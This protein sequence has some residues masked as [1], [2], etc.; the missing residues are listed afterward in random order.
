MYQQYLDILAEC[1]ANVFQEMTRTEILS[2]RIK[3][4]E[5]PMMD[6]PVAHV[7]T[8]EH[9]DHKFKGNI[10]LGFDS[11]IMATLVASAI[12]ERMGLPPVSEFNDITRDI[13]NEF[14][15]TIAGHTI[16][17]W[18]RLGM[19][20]SFGPPVSQK[21]F[22]FNTHN[23]FHTEAYLIIFSLALKHFILR[24][25]FSDNQKI[26]QKP[27]KILVVDDSMLIR[28]LLMK[29]LGDA[30]YIVQEAVNG[31]EAV[32]KFDEFAPD[33]TIM[34]LIM[35]EMGG[36]EAIC[37]IREID[38]AARIV[39]LTSTSRDDEVSTAKSLNVSEYI[40]KPVKMGDFVHKVNKL[41]N[42]G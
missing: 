37:K 42:A 10:V 32:R 3:K 12:A 4:E 33:L 39:V 19:P 38:S 17:Q 18:D 35:P 20:V 23:S 28:G 29:A 15:N 30:G 9:L 24:V 21:G 5:R 25:T 7:I 31:R 8:Y 2:T 41:L 14:I 22:A 36:I 27:R 26:Q 13:L 1:T 34:D 40:I 16:S 6:L 11:E